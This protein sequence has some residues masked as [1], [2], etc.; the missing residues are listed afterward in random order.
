MSGFDFDGHEC[1]GWR[2]ISSCF[3]K[4]LYTKLRNLYLCMHEK[5]NCRHWQVKTD[6]P[7]LQ[8][9]SFKHFLYLSQQ[10]LKKLHVPVIQYTAL[11]MSVCVFFFFSKGIP[12][13][14]WQKVKINNKLFFLL[15]PPSSQALSPGGENS[16]NEV[17]PFDNSMYRIGPDR[18]R[19]FVQ[20]RASF[21]RHCLLLFF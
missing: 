20:Q 17:A 10:F 16:G 12:M 18:E 15:L 8:V 7:R 13:S 14:T 1:S 3:L 21:I 5:S 19:V 9:P 6:W 2:S 4:E 11:S